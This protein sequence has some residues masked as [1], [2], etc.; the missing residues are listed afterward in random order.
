MNETSKSPS[1]GR[2]AH[3]GVPFPTVRL[4]KL[5]V[6]LVSA[7]V[8][9]FHLSGAVPDALAVASN[10]HADAVSTDG[11]SRWPGQW[12]IVD[13]AA[14]GFDTQALELAVQR[15]G[16][17][18]GL[19]GV[20][21]VR[22]A[23]IAA[24][25]YFRE[26]YREKPHNLKSASK[27]VISTLVGIAVDQGLLTL[28]RSIATWLPYPDLFSDR[29]KAAITPRHLLSMTSGL[30][31]TSYQTYNTWI[32]R[33][34]WVRA[35]LERPMVAEPGTVFQY[36]TGDT[37]ILS[38]IL[39]AVC[40]TSTRA[41][42]E[43][44]LFGP[45]DIRV[46][47]WDEDPGGVSLGGNNLSLLPR[48]MAKLGLLYLDGGVFGSHRIVSRGWIEDAV[49]PNALGD[50]EVYGAYGYLWYI[51]PGGREAFTAVGFGGQYIYVAPPE[52][53]IVVITSTLESKGR[54]WEKQVIGLIQ[55]GILGSLR[56]DAPHLAPTTRLRVP[57]VAGADLPRHMASV[58][59]VEGSRN[60]RPIARG[61][62]LANVVLRSAPGTG[63]VRLGL[64]P[65]DTEV[66]ILETRNRWHRVSYDRRQ[67]WISGDY[68][69]VGVQEPVGEVPPDETTVRMAASSS[70]EQAGAASAS[71]DLEAE[72]PPIP[73]FAR[74]QIQTLTRALESAESIRRAKDARLSALQQEIEEQRLAAEDKERRQR[75][76]S[77]QLAAAYDD[78]ADLEE[79]ARKAQAGESRLQ[80]ALQKQEGEVREAAAESKRLKEALSRADAGRVG[81]E[82]KL[83]A[84]LERTQR[85]EKETTSLEE[86]LSTNRALL[87]EERKTFSDREKQL[88]QEI[89]GLAE[90]L[91]QRDLMAARFEERL[92]KLSAE[93]SAARLDADRS[94]KAVAVLKAERADQD[95]RLASLERD[96][97]ESRKEK[98]RMETALAVLQADQ[99]EKSGRIEALEKSLASQK[100]SLSD[101]EAK[102]RDQAAA[103]AGAKER[104]AE[105]ERSLLAAETERKR[106]DAETDLL[107]EKLAAGR[108]SVEA[109]SS[110]RDRLSEE[111][112]ELRRSLSDQRDQ[113][114][115][116]AA[117]RSRL[118]SELSAARDALSAEREA[119]ATRDEQ[120]RQKLAALSEELQRRDAV[121]ETMKKKA[122]TLGAQLEAARSDT[123]RMKALLD[124]AEADRAAGRERL[125]AALSRLARLDQERVAAMAQRQEIQ[126]ELASVKEELLQ[127]RGEGR[128]LR[129]AV[130]K[131]TMELTDARR[132]LEVL[133][134][135][136]AG[137]GGGDSLAAAGK[138]T[139]V[140]RS[141]GAS[142]DSRVDSEAP[143]AMEAEQPSRE[144]DSVSGEALPLPAVDLFVKGWA[145]D[146]SRKDA[147]AYLARYSRRF[148]PERGRSLEAWRS[149]R[150]RRLAKPAFI[151][152]IV[153]D[154]EV[155]FQERGRAVATFRQTYRS[156]TYA[157]TV[158]KTLELTI[159]EGGWKILTENSR[160]EP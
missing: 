121:Q 22:G 86:A 153:G 93:A 144:L 160:K 109:V 37:H 131:L 120:I 127:R 1:A 148:Q 95:N 43:R 55:D 146:W 11:K 156:D 117:Q 159:E 149:I 114:E 36:S 134:Q 81:V 72:A 5:F 16:A 66:S 6:R 10:G 63:A 77:E 13:P 150:R 71:E 24:E 119:S 139:A 102:G 94:G 30:E 65:L 129:S 135:R 14:V 118:Q 28:D 82:K 34:D 18:E 141:V 3:R 113:A 105:L 56:Q 108:S 51:R 142:P 20:V 44:K 123:K 45:M 69:R 4:V 31:P 21:V 76:L 39:T 2:T 155:K 133:T 124:T 100:R 25:R 68:V 83:G 158:R 74:L 104:I 116:S 110:E 90:Q 67:G 57:G 8:L 75:E 122:E 128:W 89:T 7:V 137:S 92:K 79:Q 80:A 48:D 26:A 157:D 27:V 152:V 70:Q 15:I 17:M 49:R 107:R 99:T 52:D 106:M 91:R 112:A 50:H 143:A 53:C 96:L 111:V 60:N 29:R 19:Y 138:P 38:G 115:A 47:G 147:D 42:A 23:R 78:I 145:D 58:V 84:A 32:S 98:R 87:A 88:Q 46:Q 9:L 136:I 33:K 35:A 151:E 12:E 59:E 40:G 101:A 61:K 97:D 130:E 126:E 154:L 73:A 125:D 41:Y 54:R 85:M 132:E 64:V 103:L 140:A 62:T